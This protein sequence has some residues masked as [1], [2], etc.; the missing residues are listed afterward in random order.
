LRTLVTG[1]DFAQSTFAG[2]QLFTADTSGV[3][4]WA[5]KQPG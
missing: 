1:Q 2:H 3:Y 4:G 5:V